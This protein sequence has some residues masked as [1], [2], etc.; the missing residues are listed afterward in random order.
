MLVPIRNFAEVDSAKKIYRSAQPE[1]SYEY[2]FLKE[3]LGVDTIVN[4]RSELD[5]DSEYAGEYQIKVI[6]IPMRDHFPPTLQEANDF[7]QLVKDNTG[8][9]FH[10]LHGRGR[11]STFCVLS[12]IA[13]GWKLED[14]I[15]EEINTFGYS[16]QHPSQLAFLRENFSNEIH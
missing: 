13:L 5:H 2:K 4:L 3:R 8:I 11:T 7:I 14:A 16:F 1:Y 9:L 15:N 10:C 12:R 6:N